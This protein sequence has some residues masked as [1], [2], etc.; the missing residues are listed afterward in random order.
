MS[1]MAVQTTISTGTGRISDLGSVAHGREGS[2]GV[3]FYNTTLAHR[4]RPLT[5]S[6]AVTTAGSSGSSPSARITSGSV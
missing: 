6:I 4:Q 3:G 5:K 1:V 2:R